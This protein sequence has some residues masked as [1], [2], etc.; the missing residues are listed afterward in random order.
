MERK[1]F[2]IAV[3]VAGLIGLGPARVAQ[4]CAVT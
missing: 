4:R 2:Q 3:V 1:L